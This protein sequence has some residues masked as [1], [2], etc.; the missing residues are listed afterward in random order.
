[1]DE[2]L[3]KWIGHLDEIEDG[4]W[5]VGHCCNENHDEAFH[6]EELSRLFKLR[7]KAKKMIKSLKEVK[8]G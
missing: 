8:H 4:I 2:I 6:K 5:Q 1:M 7:S 3:V